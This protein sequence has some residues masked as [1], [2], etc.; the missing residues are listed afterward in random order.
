MLPQAASTDKLRLA[1]RGPQAG[2]TASVGCTLACKHPAHCVVES[3]LVHGRGAGSDQIAEER[4]ASH[5][6]RPAC[7]T[8][9]QQRRQQRRQLQRGPKHA[10]MQTDCQN[11]RLGYSSVSS[12]RS[13]GAAGGESTGPCSAAR[14]AG[15][16]LEGGQPWVGGARVEP[17]SFQCRNFHTQSF[18][19]A[20]A[21]RLQ[22]A[23]NTPFALRA[24][25]CG[26]RS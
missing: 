4:V 22:A 2:D 1:S 9:E 10:Q 11:R 16:Q 24:S 15:G 7:A 18:T 23:H 14:K 8:D 25:C 17:L 12:L 5:G 26:P 19:T 3:P 6:R 20:L 21:W 13:A